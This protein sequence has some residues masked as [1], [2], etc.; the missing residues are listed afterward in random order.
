MVRF[1]FVDWL[2]GWLTSLKAHGSSCC[3]EEHRGMKHVA[4]DRR[5]RLVHVAFDHAA[6]EF[7]SALDE[8]GRWDNG[9]FSMDASS[10]QETEASVGA[11]VARGRDTTQ[12]LDRLPYI[13]EQ[14]DQGPERAQRALGQFAKAPPSKRHRLTFS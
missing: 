10:R 6:A 9:L 3:C 11:T 1:R 8:V 5:G 13:L 7:A 4:R 2:A 12:C 14:L